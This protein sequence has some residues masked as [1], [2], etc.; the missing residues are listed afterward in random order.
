M[1]GSVARGI[2]LYAVAIPTPGSSTAPA[3]ASDS[4]PAA[5]S[6]PLNGPEDVAVPVSAPGPASVPDQ[7]SLTYIDGLFGLKGGIWRNHV[8]NLN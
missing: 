8:K 7:K 5:D 3:L 4:E 2:P 1:L 6:E